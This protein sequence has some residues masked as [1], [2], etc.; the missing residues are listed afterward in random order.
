MYHVS[1][2]PVSELNEHFICGL[3]F[4]YIVDATTI[5]ECPHSC[6]SAVNFGL[7]ANRSVRITF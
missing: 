5:I 7:F 6:K 2:V 4:G 1:T 3:C